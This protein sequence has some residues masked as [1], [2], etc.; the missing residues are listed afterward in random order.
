MLKLINLGG[1]VAQQVRPNELK[2]LMSY[3]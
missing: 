3:L 2:K 1:W